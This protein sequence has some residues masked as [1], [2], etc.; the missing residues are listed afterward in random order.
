MNNKPVFIQVILPLPLDG[1][2]TYSVP[3]HLQENLTT[4]KRVI[5]PFGTRKMYTGLIADILDENNS[6]YE[7]KDILEVL[8]NEAIIHP[9]QI[10]LWS[11]IANYYMCSIGEVFKAAL[12]SGL[13]IH[14]ESS[15]RL[16]PKLEDYSGLSKRE[17]DFV[18][19]L[20]DGDSINPDQARKIL[21]LK[22]VFSIVKSLQDK[23]A[24]V[25]D[26]NL[27]DGFKPKLDNYIRLTKA[28]A[29]E[30]RIN[31]LLDGLSRAKKQKQIILSFLHL[32]GYIE[33]LGANSLKKSLLLKDANASD[34]ILKSLIKKGIF[35]QYQVEVSRLGA[36]EIKVEPLKMLTAQQDVAIAQIKDQF[37]SKD[38]VLIHGVTSSGKTEVY[39]HLIQEALQQNKQVL[40]LL[41]E[42]AL[43]TQIVERL[44]K[45]FGNAVGVFH[46]KYSDTERVEIWKSIL[47]NNE[48]SY[49]IIL[50][51]RSSIFLPFSKLGL[52]I[53]D[54]EHENT[55]KQY[56]PTPRY[57]GRDAS[58]VLASIFKAKT[59][60][61]SATPSIES[62][63]NAKTGKFGLVEMPER[64]QGLELP[65]VFI[66]NVRK[67][68]YK[69]EMRAHF[70]PM[71][72]KELK[73]AFEN[74]EQVILFQNRRGFS[75]YVECNSCSFV[76]KCQQC[77][78]SLTYHRGF[79]R[80]ICHYCGYSQGIPS[81][82]PDCNGKSIS[83]R[84]FG[85]EKI[86]TE[87]SALF[88]DIRVGRLDLDTT[89]S[90]KSYERI[91][92]DFACGK[93][94]LLVGTQMISKGLDFDNVRVVGILN[95][96]SMFNFPDFRAY[97]R[98][99][100]LMA[101]VAGRAG[102]KHKRGKVVVQASDAG[103]PVVKFMFNN[104]YHGMFMAQVQERKT[105][106]Y[107]PFSRLI[108]ITLK[109]K[110][111]DALN[112][113][114]KDMAAILLPTFRKNLLGPEYPLVARVQNYYLK[115][116]ILKVAKDQ[117]ASMVR[118]IIKDAI[119]Q[120]VRKHKT[121]QVVI[122]VD[123]V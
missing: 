100:Q 120:I 75:P 105:F 18:S 66:A 118:V 45:V 46:S 119:R 14:S 121:V 4:G 122:D 117:H 60:L 12:P 67:A 93:M 78:V 65:E 29:T 5:V 111:P 50:G 3:E 30:E 15:I 97:E 21:G 28:F 116:I 84:G 55:F 64:Y 54:E 90:K 44:R 101:Q 69:K 85:T 37:K 87:I 68:R 17:I 1:F 81:Q 74:K 79:G 73:T 52:I 57:N 94:D 19:L 70:T 24:V 43:T 56:A 42:I 16:N 63:Y 25:L 80:L 11:W 41:P 10:Q 104:D 20:E 27:K 51:A 13:Q 49:K 98:S 39:I 48:S 35:E 33:T 86:E 40:Y 112:S 88:P 61:G 99:Y 6:G 109:H 114:A 110:V 103:H 62:Y 36:D 77:D 92:N 59:I 96:D 47:Q 9:Q 34:T 32:T 123:P 38:T 115:N 71:L 91:I 8:D 23:G 83:T 95:A 106:N 53:V 31:E 82:C 26:E 2:F 76:P 113:A 108:K 7:T 22:T 107:P 89:R 72:L 58:I 102:R